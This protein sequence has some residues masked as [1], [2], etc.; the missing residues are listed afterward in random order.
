MEVADHDELPSFSQTAYLGPQSSARLSQRFLTSTANWHISKGIQLPRHLLPH[1]VSPM[2]EH[3]KTSVAPSFP[4]S[5]DV[6]KLELHSLIPPSTQRAIID[7]YLKVVAPEYT[8]LVIEQDSPLFIHE[9]PLKWFSLNRDNAVA[10]TVSIVFAISTSL[11]TRDIDSNLANISSRC[12]EEVQRAS[13]GDLPFRDQS[14]EPIWTC[15]AL[16]ALALCEL[17]VPTS[18]QIWDL[19]GRAASTMED[20][21]G[22]CR[23]RRSDLDPGLRRLEHTLLK[24]EMYVQSLLL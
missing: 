20:L 22:A 24:L 3:E 5:K 21:Q 12:R 15:T 1:D 9:N 18:G 23:L 8:F 17:I 11:V 6:R 4:I 7:H 19:L 10:F 14:G 13:V 2:R 16:C